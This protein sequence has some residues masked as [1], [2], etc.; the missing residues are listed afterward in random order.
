VLG[1]NDSVEAQRKLMEEYPNNPH[2]ETMK[3]IIYADLSDIEAKLLAWDHNSYNE[4]RMSMTLIQRVRFIH[5]EFE[6]KCG[7]DKINVT[8]DFRKE[9]CM[10]IGY[11]IEEKIK[12][13]GNIIN[14]HIFRGIDNFF[15]LA[16]RTGEI[17]EL[18]NGIFNMWE[19]IGIKNQKVKRSKPLI[20]SNSKSGPEIKKLLEDMTITPWRA[21]QGVKD[22]KLVKE[23]L[24]HMRSRELSL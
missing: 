5:S 13:K 8:V 6:E 3:C 20:C 1:G 11:Q 4:Y 24:C 19:N 23:I 18:I 12:S 15:Q 16:F 21:L 2:F 10:E 22:E 17:W 14:T 9:C 7:G